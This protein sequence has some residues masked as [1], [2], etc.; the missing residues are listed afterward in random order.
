MRAFLA[1]LAAAVA[2]ATITAGGSSASPPGETHLV[3]S[4]NWQGLTFVVGLESCDLL[5]D[6]AFRDVDLTDHLNIWY[7]WVE[8][9]ILANS[10]ATYGGVINTPAGTYRVHGQSV[11]EN[12]L[13]GL[14]GPFIGTDGHAT[15][16]GPNGVVSGAARF[17]DLLD[18]GP[19]EMD[20]IFTSIEVC[21]LK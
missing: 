12:G 5:G 4:N 18:W 1:L 15:I 3:I 21:K 6:V 10:T 13:W 9:G 7:T 19:P 20:I 11:E 16:K 17:Q 14:L 8:N 2:A